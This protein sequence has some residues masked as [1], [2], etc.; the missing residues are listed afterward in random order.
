MI[1]CTARLSLRPLTPAD[2]PFMLELLNQPSWIEQ[3]GDRGVRD[4]EGAEAYIRNGPMASYARHGFG[5]W[6][7]ERTAAALPV[8]ICGILQRDYLD[9]PDLGYAFLER[10][11]GQGFASE[12]TA[13]TVAYGRTAFGISRMYAFVNPGNAPSIR[14]L[15]KVGM[16]FLRRMH[17][18]NDPIEVS[19]YGTGG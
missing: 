5:L 8:G 10:F 12:T 2:A 6:C 7:V 9:A 14:V 11:Q 15:E 1:L 4:L 3:I 16:T 17:L 18:P 13:T 19:L